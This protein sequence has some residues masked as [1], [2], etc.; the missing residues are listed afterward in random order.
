M[1]LIDHHCHSVVSDDLSD[2][3]FAALLTESDRAPAPGTSPWDSALGLAVRRWCPPVLDLDPY[4][5]ATDYLT[6]RRDLGP[7]EATRRL[8]R[9]AGLDACFV[10]TGLDAAGGAAL[11]PLADFARASGAEVREVVRLEYV[12]ERASAGSQASR[13]ADDVLAALREAVRARGA[14][15]VKSVLAYRHGLDIDPARP[16]PAEVARAAGEYLAGP[17]RRLDHPVLL[18]HL[19]WTA[20]DLGL[21]I[22]IHTGFGDPDLTLHRANPSLLTGFIRAS[23]PFGVPLVLLH[24]WPYHREAAW[25]AQAFPLVYCD[26]GLTLSYV[27]PGA[28]NVLAETL[29]LAP[30][31]KVLFSTDAYGL[32]ELYAVGAAAFRDAL[33]AWTASLRGTGCPAEDADLITELIGAANAS[34]L[35]GYS[36]TPRGPQGAGG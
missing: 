7:A 16:G 33:G 30:F 17:S 29:E 1:G 11:L 8:L 3:A 34:R 27:G 36:P 2:E 12:A 14:V 31:G 32:P 25:L 6:R 35:Y 9:A 22:Q 15:A 4:A 23:E 26:V 19:L 13:W 10:D 5:P 20:V 24:C 18:R 21:P 28:R